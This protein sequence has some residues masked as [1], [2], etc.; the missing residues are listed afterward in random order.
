MPV[1]AVEDSIE[2]RLQHAE[3]ARLSGDFPAAYKI[4][5]QLLDDAPGNQDVN[6]SYGMTCLEL[7]YTSRAELAF[8]RILQ[9]N[10]GNHRAR[11]ELARTLTASGRF[12]EAQVE[13]ETVLLSNPPPRVRE[14]IENYLAQVRS[15]SGKRFD[16]GFQLE[17][18]IFYDSNVNVGPKADII[19]IDPLSFGFIVIDY[20]T[21][22]KDSKPRGDYGMYLSGRCRFRFDPGHPGAWSTEAGALF[23]ANTM[24][25]EHDYRLLYYQLHAA[26]NRSV[27][28][29]QITLPIRYSHIYRSG[30]SLMQSVGGALSYGAILPPG[31]DQR[32]TLLADLQWRDYTDRSDRD[33]LYAFGGMAFDQFIGKR[34]HLAGLG[35]T[36]YRDFADAAIYEKSG[37][38]W[39]LQ[40]TLNLP[41]R[42]ALYTRVHYSVEEYREREPLAPD[43]R[44][45]T[46]IQ[47]TIGLR[48]RLTPQWFFDANHQATR[49]ESSFDLYDYRRHVTTVSTSYFF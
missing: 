15:M 43:D 14:N 5:G 48:K 2:T 30:D 33:G 16:Q 44:K 19:P 10:P 35:V 7:G 18:G 38:R 4:L 41:W 25:T 34:K 17:L 1:S 11:L 45:D 8:Q 39:N 37:L 28:E 12:L 23:H 6:F 22:G 36:Y 21:V 26:L 31:R 13:L 20:L 40:G 32:V 3:N 46:Q 29:H 47:A 24:Y 9:I 27:R 49:N 42:C